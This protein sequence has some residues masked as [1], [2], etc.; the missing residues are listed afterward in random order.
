MRNKDSTV[1]RWK[2]KVRRSGENSRARYGK[3]LL[4]IERSLDW[5]MKNLSSVLEDCSGCCMDSGVIGKSG[6]FDSVLFI[7][8]NVKGT[9]IPIFFFK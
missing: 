2:G 9:D 5:G 4:V 7:F 1:E 8:L 3:A 6:P